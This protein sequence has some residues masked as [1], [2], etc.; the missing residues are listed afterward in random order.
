MRIAWLAACALVLLWWIGA[1]GLDDQLA[2]PLKLES[3]MYVLLAM[4][5]LAFP[6]GI[7]WAVVIAGV[8]RLL[9]EFGVA[10]NGSI[11]TGILIFWVGAV[12]LGYLQWFVLLP[13][14]RAKRNPS[15]P[16]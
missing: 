9:H 7:I 3:Q 4:C 14:Y 11:W 1:F 16:Q 8:A 6:A 5:I 12:V 2:V 13:K 15:I 10:T